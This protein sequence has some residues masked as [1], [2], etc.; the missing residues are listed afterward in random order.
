[1]EKPLKIF[2]HE[3]AL[4]RLVFLENLNM[5]KD[6]RLARRDTETIIRVRISTWEF[7]RTFVFSESQE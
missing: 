3:N 4:T 2:Q 1:M 6:E 5:I 7:L